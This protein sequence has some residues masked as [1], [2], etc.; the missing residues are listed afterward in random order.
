[1]VLL[2][3]YKRKINQ[4]IFV[5]KPELDKFFMDQVE[6]LS[7]NGN[8]LEKIIFRKIYQST[9]VYDKNG[10][11]TGVKSLNFVLELMAYL[12]KAKDNKKS[13]SE[14]TDLINLPA[15]F[16]SNHDPEQDMGMIQHNET[17]IKSL[18]KEVLSFIDNTKSLGIEEGLLAD[19]NEPNILSNTI[20]RINSYLLKK[21]YIM[22]PLAVRF[23]MYELR[24]NM[25]VKHASLKEDNEK[26]WESITGYNNYFDIK[27]DQ[28]KDEHV[29][30][31]AEAYEIYTRRD[32]N[33]IK[34]L[35]KIFGKT[36][37]LEEFKENYT[38]RTKR[39]V[40]LLNQYA[41]TRLQEAVLSGLLA[42]VN[43]M[44]D[45]IEKLFNN[46]PDVHSSLIRESEG[47]L[48][49]HD[50]QS[51][52]STQFV[53]GRADLKEKIYA[54][55]IELLDD[56]EFPQDLSRLIYAGL[57]NNVYLKVNKKESG[58]DLAR[59]VAK[60]FTVDVIDKQTESLQKSLSQDIV[61]M[62]VINAIRYEARLTG[63]DEFEHLKRHFSNA[64]ML[65]NPL[66]AK[67][68]SKA[69]HINSWALHPDCLEMGTLTETEADEIMGSMGDS[70]NGAYRILSGFFTRYEVIREDSRFL[71]SVPDNYPQFSSGNKANVYS[72]APLGK[73]YKAYKS[74]IEEVLNDLSVSPHLDK[75]WHFPGYFPDLGETREVV[76]EKIYRAFFWGLINRDL[77]F[78][79]E[80]GDKRWVFLRATSNTSRIIQDQHQK[81]I[82]PTIPDLIFKGLFSNP[83]I[84]DSIVERANKILI[85]NKS[86]FESNYNLDRVAALVNLPLM[87]EITG[88]RI[89]DIRQLKDLP[90]IA[91]I[92]KVA[93]KDKDKIVS[94]MLE[95]VV[96]CCIY[97]GGSNQNSKNAIKKITNNLLGITGKERN[98]R[99]T[100]IENLMRKKFD[101]SAQS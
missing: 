41:V 75:R 87:K 6:F 89:S 57:F 26:A 5:E 14:I 73:Y 11:Q 81:N 72:D 37:S 7:K 80:A 4:G 94:I 23:F 70:S 35:S 31:A 48:G 100:I 22:H 74:R 76:A 49:M 82:E 9:L 38:S 58:A 67:N 53:L 51:D 93:L 15:E 63:Q 42:Q 2:K 3:D 1:T 47:L 32:K 28:E 27:D 12:E 33:M 78:R 86:E 44:I 8:G 36:G 85:E 83:G 21:D 50:Q 68:I 59:S 18:H 56:I 24:R 90:L 46:L 20:S 60:L 34:K 43:V 40:S 91:V 99:T 69:P 96:D 84:V 52:K 25:Q 64:V 77:S 71:L 54:E 101:S 30:T 55:K 97:I 16:H 19:Y 39:Q 92:D 65:A 29:E 61:G 79:D 62:N 17:V 10:T 45:E 13:I 66:G 88:Y 98:T 95:I